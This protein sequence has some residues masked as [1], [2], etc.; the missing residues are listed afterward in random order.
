[1]RSNVN[2]LTAASEATVVQSNTGYENSTAAHVVGDLGAHNQVL[3]YSIPFAEFGTGHTIT[4]GFLLRL[5]LTGI[6]GDGTGDQA[7]T[8]PAMLT[9]TGVVSGGPPV[10]IRQPG[11]T[12]AFVGQTINFTVKAISA[13][14]MTYQW[15]KDGSPITG[16]TSSVY[17]IGSVAHTDAASYY[18]VVCNT[19]GCVTS[20]TVTLTVSDASAGFNFHQDGCFMP[21]TLIRLPDGTEKQ[22]RNLKIG[23]KV[24]SYSIAG[25]NPDDE[26]A[27]KTWTTTSLTM[28][29]GTA[30]IKDIYVQTFSGYFQ[31]LDLRVT[32]EHP[33]LSRRNGVWAF[34]EVQD[35]K[36]GDFLWKNG[37]TIP[38]PG[39]T[40]VPGKVATY[41]LNVE[42]TDVFVASG[43]LAPNNFFKSVWRF[44]TPETAILAAITSGQSLNPFNP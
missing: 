6:N 42:R 32:Y 29:Q 34:R 22:I 7:F 30:T 39:M 31:L 21:D 11:N 38:F 17:V 2:I 23:D 18:V 26:N 28:A 19:F 20:N 40:Y 25:L 10:I 4:N 3:F 15:Y 36:K 5:Q 9:G 44:I 35:L 27:W 37:A 41:N 1:M 24:L 12:Q 33:I 14:P 43:F 13:D 8:V 16:A